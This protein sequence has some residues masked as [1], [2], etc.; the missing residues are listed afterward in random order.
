[1][2]ALSLL[3]PNAISEANLSKYLDKG[4]QVSQVLTDQKVFMFKANA[5]KLANLVDTNA[6]VANSGRVALTVCMLSGDLDDEVDKTRQATVIML[7]AEK[8][9][10]SREEMVRSL[11]DL[12]DPA[13]VLETPNLVIIPFDSDC[14]SV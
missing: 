8:E 5:A 12:D 2:Q 1:M 6:D 14:K 3:H 4:L 7:N 10:L 9:I 13:Q 11:E